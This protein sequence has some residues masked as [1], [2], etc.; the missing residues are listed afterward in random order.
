MKTPEIDA[1]SFLSNKSEAEVEKERRTSEPQTLSLS[2]SLR[3]ALVF[4]ES[5]ALKQK[6]VNF[7]E[8]PAENKFRTHWEALCGEWICSEIIISFLGN[9]EMISATVLLLGF[10]SNLPPSYKT[11]QKCDKLNEWIKKLRRR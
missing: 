9:T 7:D 10:R 5:H 8:T 3:S 2:F 1:W 4:V 11:R 6:T